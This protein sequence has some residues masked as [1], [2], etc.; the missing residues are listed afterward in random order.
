MKYKDG[1]NGFPIYSNLYNNFAYIAETQSKFTFYKSIGLNI[2]STSKYLDNDNNVDSLNNAIFQTDFLNQ[3]C[4]N[5]RI[6]YN[7]SRFKNPKLKVKLILE[8]IE[9]QNN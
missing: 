7:F 4:I 2:I 6:I 5:N 1:N 3:N 9:N 8:P